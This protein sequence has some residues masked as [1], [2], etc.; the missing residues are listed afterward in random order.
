[1]KLKAVKRLKKDD[2]LQVKLSQ[3]LL[4]VLLCYL[5]PITNAFSF[6]VI[7]TVRQVIAA[8][9]L[10]FSSLSDIQNLC[11]FAKN[12]TLRG[13]STIKAQCRH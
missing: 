13:Y 3:T 7:K 11:D 5:T 4:N 6:S 8:A 2:F 12:L 1:M 10:V 9:Y